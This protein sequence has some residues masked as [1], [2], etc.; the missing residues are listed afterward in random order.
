MILPSVKTNLH[1]IP[2]DE[3]FFVWF[4]HSSYYLQLDGKK[5]L[6]DPVFS[7]NA[8]PIPGTVKSFK[9]TNTYVAED[10]PEIDYHII[11]HDHWDHLDYDTMKKLKSRI[12]YII[13]GLGVRAHLEKWG[14]DAATI[15]EMDW[16]QTLDL[17]A[18]FIVNSVAGRHFSGRGLKRQQS[19]WLSIVLSTPGYNIFIGG[20][21]GYDTHFKKTGDEFGP[22]DIAFLECGQYNAAWKYIH[23]MPEE[24]AKA[25][26]DLK[27]KRFIPVHWGKFA[28]AYHAW[29]EPVMRVV[30]A[31]AEKHVPVVTP[32]I[33]EKVLLDAPEKEWKKWWEGI[34]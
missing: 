15:H 27:A 6:V 34:I 12:N 9:G 28:L 29:D 24:V 16:D 7:G 10:I 20:D 5:I 26:K 32:M 33:G 3:H 19:L 1:L 21:S 23:M 22:F 2:A 11:T 4:G 8:S 31:A 25:A 30:K 18:G 14:F 17:G 13:T